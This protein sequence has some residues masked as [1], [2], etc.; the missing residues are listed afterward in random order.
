MNQ[1]SAQFSPH[2]LHVLQ[3]GAEPEMARIHACW[4]VPSGTVMQDVQAI[5]DLPS[6]DFPRGAVCFDLLTVLPAAA[7][8][9]I[10]A[11]ED[12]PGPQPATTRLA[13]FRPEAGRNW[14]AMCSLSDVPASSR[15]VT[16]ALSTLGE[17]VRI[18]G[19]WSAAYLADTGD[20]A[21][22]HGTL[23]VHRDHPLSRNRGA[24]PRAGDNSIGA[25]LRLDFTI[26]DQI[27]RLV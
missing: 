12:R 17:H 22:L 3:V 18:D 13:D 1:A 16:A 20:A 8:M 26:S 5:G 4:I 25:F 27:E 9:P 23:R 10:S 24:A 6:V 7:K 15:A 19:E 21:W 14:N 11:I 2:I